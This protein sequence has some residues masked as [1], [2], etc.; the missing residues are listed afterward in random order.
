MCHIRIFAKRSCEWLVRIEIQNDYLPYW[1]TLSCVNSLQ[2]EICTWIDG[3]NS[4][5]KI[6][7]NAFEAA[8]TL[9]LCVEFNCKNMTRIL[10]FAVIFAAKPITRFSRKFRNTYFHASCDKCNMYRLVRIVLNFAIYICSAYFH[11]F[12]FCRHILMW[13]IA[14]NLY[15]Y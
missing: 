4:Y 12:F 1:T 15:L 6:R 5:I 3:I 11:P 13:Y 10:C 14:L 9:T 2:D 7:I 8:S